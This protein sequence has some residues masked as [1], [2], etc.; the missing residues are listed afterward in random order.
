[1]LEP[2]AR[3]RRISGVI[4]R[5][6]LVVTAVAATLALAPTAGAKGPISVEICGAS[7]C[8]TFH[9]RTHWR[10]VTGVLDVYGSFS[11]A[12]ASEP[13]RYYELRIKGPGVEEWLGEDRTI[14]FVPSRGVVRSSST[15]FRPGAALLRSLRA[16]VRRLRPWPRPA[17]TRVTVNA[18]TAEPAAYEALLGVLPGAEP[19]P[20]LGD[21]VEIRFFF[22]RA[23]AWTSSRRPIQFFPTQNVIHR[24]IEWFRPPSELARRIERDAGLAPR[25]AAPPPN[26]SAGPTLLAAAV[27]ATLA[28]LGAAAVA[29]RRARRPQAASV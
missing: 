6:A 23:T 15:W 27:A 11:F 29:L 25:R 2:S 24:D 8:R 18:R 19:A 9:D 16:A 7:D 5:A 10:L 26:G 1:V 4:R 28:A 13:A 22:E 17:P 20:E 14:Y 21:P 12:R 3:L